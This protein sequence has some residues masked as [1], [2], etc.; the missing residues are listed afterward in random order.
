[1]PTIAPP[2]Y[3]LDNPVVKV[4]S[5]LRQQRRA[6]RRAP[7]PPGPTNISPVR[8]LRFV[9]DPVAMLLESYER[10]GPIFTI[11][12]FHG[13]SVVMLG[14][15]AQ[16]FL[17]VAGAEKVH[18]REG[19]YRELIP[20]LGD[21]LI[22]TDDEYH[23]RSR[24]LM[25]P[26]FHTER[27]AAATRVM[28]EEVDRALERWRPGERIDIYEWARTLGMRVAMRALFGFDPDALGATEVAREFER[29]ISFYGNDLA[30]WLLRGPGTPH[31]RLRSARKRLAELVLAEIDRRRGG[32]LDGEDV[33]SLL[34]RAED[35][36]EWRLSDRQLLDHSLTLLFAGHDTTSTTVALLLYELAQ[37]PH[38]RARVT[39]EL[40]RQLGEQPTGRDELFGRL[41]LLEQALDETLRLYPPVPAGQ[42]R[43]IAA[44]E[45]AGHH[46]PAGMH[47]QYFPW[48]SHRLG[49]VFCDPHSFRPE[50]MAPEAKATL[51]KG[52]Y[53]PFGGGRRIC[54]GKRFGHLEAKVVVSRVLQR[55]ALTLD[56]EQGGRARMKWSATLRPVGGVPMRIA[57]R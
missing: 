51:P 44:F 15:E 3:T 12:F 14:P 34:M 4:V 33:L 43:S 56:V 41:P 53:V 55:F 25:R 16:H 45:L 8:D 52:A 23:E 31:A 57:S 40:D 42:R 29:A 11:R 24:A 21:G 10:Y 19:M 36:D 2:R 28:V 9:R 39:E 48:A 20:L 47:L 54:L 32:T 38:W 35:A 27:L 17:L 13:L 50:R 1:M 26:V 37:H 30:L 46:V 5:D 22:T 49:D 6:A 7:L 18:W